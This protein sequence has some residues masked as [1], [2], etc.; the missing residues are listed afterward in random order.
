MDQKKVPA[1]LQFSNEFYSLGACASEEEG[2]LLLEL[3]KNPTIAA[4]LPKQR[5]GMPPI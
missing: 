1:I 3:K 5:E 2:K 4:F